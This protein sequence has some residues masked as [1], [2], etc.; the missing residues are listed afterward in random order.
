VTTVIS[1]LFCIY[2]YQYNAHT[3]LTQLDETIK[4]NLEQL[5][6]GLEIPL[7]SFDNNSIRNLLKSALK[8][9]HVE[10]VFLWQEGVD[11]S[12][13]YI[14]KDNEILDLK[15]PPP[16]NGLS[17]H[18]AQVIHQNI[19]IGKLELYVTQEYINKTLHQIL[20]SIVIQIFFLDI[21]L[22][23]TMMFL[24]KRIFIG[25]IK[26][27]TGSSMAIAAGNL[28][29]TIDIEF[30]E[31]EIGVLS[32][33]FILMRDS[34]KSYIEELQKEKAY[35]EQ[36]FESPPIAIVRGE[37]GIV[38]RINKEF[39]RLFGYTPEEASGREIGSLILPI[40]HEDLG[41]SLEDKGSR[42]E[43]EVERRNKSGNLVQVSMMLAPVVINEK[44]VGEYALYLDITR[45]KHAEEELRKAH[46]ELEKR[47]EERTAELAQAMQDLARAKEMAEAANK[48]KSEFLANMSHE[49]RTPLNAIMGMSGL[50]L[51][52]ELKAEQKEFL[53]IIRSSSD[54]LLQ[55]IN[56][57]LDF[58][59]IEAGKMDFEKID[60]D[61]RSQI[62]DIAGMLAL[63]AQ[64]KGIEFT[65]YID[66][67]TPSNIRGDP[68]RLRQV[69]TNLTNN[70]IKF[71]VKGEVVI[72][73][74]VQ[75]ESEKGIKLCFTISDTGIGISSE[76]IPKLFKSFHQVD[77]STTRKYGGTG[78]G[79]AIAK[80]LV[81]LMGGEI[82][83]ES[84][85]G[86][87]SKFWFSVV[88]EKVFETAEKKLI[89]PEKIRGKRILIVDDKK[90]NIQIMKTYLEKWGFICSSAEDGL[91]AL[92]IIEEVQKIQT[93]SKQ[94]TGRAPF[95]VA[96]IDYQMPGMDG[97]ELGENIKANPGSQ[98]ILMIMLTSRGMRG[99]A[100]RAKETGFAA[101]LTKPIRRS[102]FFDCL[103][104][105]LS[106]NEGLQQK[107]QEI[108][109]KYTVKESRKKMVRIL[110][111][112]DNII[113]Q[114]LALR[115]IEKFGYHADAVANGIEAI[116][117]LEL[118]PYH[119]VLMDVQMPEMDGLEATRIIRNPGS[120]VL[121]HDIPIIA[122]TAHAMKGDKEECLKIGMNDYL[123][124][125]IEPKQLS[126]M[127]E[128]YINDAQRKSEIIN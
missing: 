80:R 101:Y 45:R 74:S 119:L 92:K 51:D 17:L 56:D 127:I 35:L 79:L 60:F 41:L 111:A 118:V 62:D 114:K 72:H 115:L 100:A 30:R 68:G 124:K 59:K 116:K 64:K 40:N 128:K 95:D 21:A 98:N 29:K 9:K 42:K 53:E 31:D 94:L 46:D 86:K 13:G 48:S 47:V 110:V 105:V 25:P 104:N 22:V 126:E 69:I 82:G 96:I 37:G 117:V 122:L 5:S 61:L 89:P 11:D 57:I 81:E 83:V 70:A 103:I 23:F 84:E 63:A 93:Q 16:Q 109:T 20:L 106:S 26:T 107:P 27:L 39:T 1:I 85:L 52:T 34:I 99:D 78:L 108:V 112:E 67:E 6:V 90:I 44:T 15:Q 120:N 102:E 71:T 65:Y 73:V 2:F 38:K 77:A 113:N 87:G 55:I 12:Y 88:M 14:K 7:F 24:L 19:L 43:S 123:P 75:H 4:A 33:N 125:P 91:T 36:L 32:K 97:L 58:S 28:D 10:A 3:L 121:D 50:M 54:S 49:I 8:N 76:Q 18:K 66:D